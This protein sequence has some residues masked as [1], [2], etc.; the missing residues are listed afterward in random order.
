MI[1]LLGLGT[2]MNMGDTRHHWARP[3]RCTKANHYPLTVD[4]FHQLNAGGT[5]CLHGEVLGASATCALSLI[6]GTGLN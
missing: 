2:S 1:V 5:D 3:H 4:F 6:T